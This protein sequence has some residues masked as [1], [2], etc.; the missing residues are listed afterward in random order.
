M[1]E[2]KLKKNYELLNFRKYKQD[3]K[4]GNKKHTFL[5]I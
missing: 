5:K 3:K 1:Y 2:Y 4:F